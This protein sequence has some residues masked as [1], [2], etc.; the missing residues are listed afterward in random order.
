MACG[1][2]TN[3]RISFYLPEANVHHE[4]TA[5]TS[6]DFY[7]GRIARGRTVDLRTLHFGV[8]MILGLG[9]TS[10]HGVGWSSLYL[11]NKIGLPGIGQ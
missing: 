10:G 8:L 3:L 7:L 5:F 11:C 1:K 2:H 4:M 9:Y 6:Q